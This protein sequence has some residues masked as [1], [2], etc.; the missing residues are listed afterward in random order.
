MDVPLNMM[1]KHGHRKTIKADG[2]SWIVEK[3]LERMIK[4][5]KGEGGDG[6]VTLL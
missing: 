1:Y 2:G 5:R 6:R 3:G 4:E